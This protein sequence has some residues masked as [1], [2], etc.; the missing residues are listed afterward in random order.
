[1]AWGL[2]GTDMQTSYGLQVEPAGLQVTARGAPAVGPIDTVRQF[3]A[4]IGTRNYAAAWALL[5]PRYQATTTYPNWVAGYQNTRSVMLAA[6]NAVD[7]T[8]VAVSV[9][10]TDSEGGRLVPKT[11]QGTWAVVFL[12]DAWRLDAGKIRQVN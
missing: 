10:A 6:V 3:Y 7:P 9:L 12:N 5:S 11:F 2:L 1:M 4:L 8:T